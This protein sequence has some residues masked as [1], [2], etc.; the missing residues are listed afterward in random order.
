ML[1]L[2]HLVP[3]RVTRARI[4]CNSAVEKIASYAGVFRGARVSW[5]GMENELPSKTPSWEAMEKINKRN[6]VGNY[7]LRR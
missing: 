3:S 6:G 4:F 7:L 5:G 2:A 1:I